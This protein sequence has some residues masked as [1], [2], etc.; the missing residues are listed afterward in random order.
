LA[1]PAAAVGKAAMIE[2]VTQCG[3]VLP[4]PDKKSHN[5]IPGRKKYKQNLIGP[6]LMPMPRAV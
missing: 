4:R 3:K 2:G 6:V 1:A 5:S